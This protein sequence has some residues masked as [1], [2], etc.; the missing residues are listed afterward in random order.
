[1]GE[2]YELTGCLS[3]LALEIRRTL[4]EAYNSMILA[5]T[6]AFPGQTSYCQIDTIQIYSINLKGYVTVN[7]Y[8]FRPEIKEDKFLVKVS[9][10]SPLW[11][12]GDDS[13]LPKR[14]R[15][16]LGKLLLAHGGVQFKDK[17]TEP[18]S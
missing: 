18:P 3:D 14:L 10:F 11:S 8:Y 12:G 1:M 16:K 9:A 6:S 15:E 2:T 17:G 4:K 7:V 13:G 5:D